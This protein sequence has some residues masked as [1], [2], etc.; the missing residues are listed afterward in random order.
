MN[1][2][3]PFSESSTALISVCVVQ[4]LCVE[5][6][7]LLV[8]ARVAGA[9]ARGRRAPHAANCG[10][11]NFDLG[12]L[13]T[14]DGVVSALEVESDLRKASFVRLKTHTDGYDSLGPPVSTF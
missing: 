7:P 14:P 10:L 8:A 4:L 2:L 9:P 11:L 5:F 13:C 3:F 1:Q 6:E 12:R